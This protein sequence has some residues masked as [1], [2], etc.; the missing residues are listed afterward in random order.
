MKHTPGPW[1]FVI[2]GTGNY[3][4]WNIQLGDRGFFTLPSTASMETM[5]ADARLIESAPEL[6]M[7]L[8]KIVGS[9]YDGQ[10]HELEN[11][12]SQANYLVKRIER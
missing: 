12:L 8:K 9:V 3:P 6:L 5:D 2:G 11:L 4:L 1:K 10:T 7:V